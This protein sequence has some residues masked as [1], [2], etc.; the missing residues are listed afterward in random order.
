MRSSR[1]GP[2]SAPRGRAWRRRLERRELARARG[3]LL[4]LALEVEQRVVDADGHADQQHHAATLLVAGKIWLAIAVRPI[5]A[6]TDES[7]SSTGMPA[8]RRAPK[9]MT[10]IDQRDREREQPG[11]LE[12]RGERLVE[13]AR[14]AVASPNY[15][16]KSS[17]CA[18][19][20]VDGGDHRADLVP[21][22]S[23]SPR[24][25]KTMAER[26]S[27]DTSSGFPVQGS[28]RW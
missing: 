5:A 21:A 10:R 7:A 19:A 3:A 11:L 22:F 20:P 2:R 4:A 28:G 6:N 8:A 14:S 1:S 24:M 25:S 13:P 12:V 26:P 16:M 17:G 9:A 18:F 27:A 23:G 15:P